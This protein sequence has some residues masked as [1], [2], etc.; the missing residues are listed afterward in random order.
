MEIATSV[1]GA[2]MGARMDWADSS[3]WTSTNFRNETTHTKVTLLAL[4]LRGGMKNAQHKSSAQ[5]KLKII[6][7]TWGRHE[8]HVTVVFISSAQKC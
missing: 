1:T 8:K 3:K 4:L 5:K 7:N 6:K 2:V